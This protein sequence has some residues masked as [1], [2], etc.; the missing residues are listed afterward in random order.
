MRE[1][2][3]WEIFPRCWCRDTEVNVHDAVRSWKNHWTDGNDR[4]RIVDRDLCRLSDQCMILE[5]GDTLRACVSGGHGSESGK[6]SMIVG[7]G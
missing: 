7:Y 1:E 5:I 2:N 6:I 4:S 3:N